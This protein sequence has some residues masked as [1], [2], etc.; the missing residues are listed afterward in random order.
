[1]N[2]FSEI[3]LGA[4][5]TIDQTVEFIENSAWTDCFVL[6]ELYW[7]TTDTQQCQ[8]YDSIENCWFFAEAK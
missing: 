5:D 4:K 6:T 1:M 2:P 3:L 8:Q 7:N